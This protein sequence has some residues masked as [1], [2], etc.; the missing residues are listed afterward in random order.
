MKKL[1]CFII[2]YFSLSGVLLHAGAGYIYLF[3][4]PLYDKAKYKAL[5]KFENY[6][7]ALAYPKAVAIENYDLDKEIELNFGLWQHIP[8]YP[9]GHTPEVFY[10]D[11]FDS[12]TSAASSLSHGSTLVIKEGVYRQPLIITANDVTVIGLGHVVI[13]D[14]SAEGKAAIVLKGN[15]SSIA[16]IECRYIKVQHDNGACIRLEGKNLNID[17]VYFHSS[18]QGILSGQNSGQVLIRNSRFEKLGYKGYAH[19]IYIGGGELF[20]DNSLFIAAKNQGHEIKSRALSTIIQNSIITSLSSD[21]SRLIDF[22]NGGRLTIT[23]SILHQGP[24]SK[25]MDAIGFGLERPPSEKDLITIKNSSIILERSGSNRFI[26]FA[27]P[28][29]TR[30][31]ENNLIITNEIPN[32]KDSNMTFTSRKEAGLPSYPNLKFLNQ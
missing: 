26:H 20:I 28:G 4:K 5:E 22:P 11:N 29:T 7:P 16:N 19:G 2:L 31:I 14:T 15:Y 17:H 30:S 21:D 32:L 12:L 8:N 18:Q 25:N 6:F 10:S 13:E 24:R 3:N 9:I 1:T 27:D 23:H